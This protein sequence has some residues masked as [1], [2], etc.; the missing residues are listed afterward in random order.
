M[1]VAVAVAQPSTDT[2]DVPVPLHAT[3]QPEA[4]EAI[5]GDIEFATDDEDTPEDDEPLAPSLGTSEE[6]VEPKKV[7]KPTSKTTVI[8]LATYMQALEHGIGM[9]TLSPEE[10]KQVKSDLAG[11]AADIHIETAELVIGPG[12]S[13]LMSASLLALIYARDLFGTDMSALMSMFNPPEPALEK[14]EWLDTGEGGL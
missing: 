3:A 13:M 10:L 12:T 7:D 6:Y 1:P 8:K 2:P 9:T 11:S 4:P 5:E 14:D